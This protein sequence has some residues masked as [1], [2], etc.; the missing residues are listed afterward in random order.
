MWSFILIVFNLEDFMNIIGFSDITEAI[1]SLNYDDKIELN[2]LLRHYLAE[3]RREEIYKNYEN[4][5]NEIS[6]GKVKYYSSQSDLRKA[7]END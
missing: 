4:S 5:K 2:E 7:L 6:E 1:K 3:E